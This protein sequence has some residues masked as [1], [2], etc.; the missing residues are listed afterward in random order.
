MTLGNKLLEI[1]LK[2]GMS[3]EK[4]GELLDTTR[5]TVSKWE[6]DQVVPDVRKLI[7]ISRIFC[8]SLDDMLLNVTNFEMEGVPFQCGVYKK[9]TSEIVETEKYALEYYARGKNIMGAK[10]YYGAGDQK[11]LLAICEKDVK[12]LRISYAYTFH[13]VNGKIC[14]ISNSKDFESRLNIERLDRKKLEKMVRVNSFLVNHGEYPLHTVYEIGIRRCLEEWTRGVRVEV[15]SERFFV[16][17]HTGKK[18]YVYQIRPQN[19][20]IYC[21]IS[22]N[23]A[24]DLGVRSYGQYYRL[25][26]YK[27]N[28]EAFCG[29]G[30]DFDYQMPNELHSM[31]YGKDIKNKLGEPEKNENGIFLVK[32][33]SDDEIVLDGCGGDEYIYDRKTVMSERFT[34]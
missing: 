1:R 10:V 13:D 15:N 30:F 25:R 12:S 29:C 2:R 31:N 19:E 33:Y 3:Q 11:I 8:V 18:E 23:I 27:D 5:Q 24:F 7:A 22:Y 6:L 16:N 32:R 17:L 4:F 14:T 34:K 26:N 9:E 20:D 28:S 21:G